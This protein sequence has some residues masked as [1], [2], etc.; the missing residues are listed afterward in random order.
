[1]WNQAIK[2]LSAHKLRLALT[3][4]AVILGVAFMAGTLVLTGTIKHTIDGL[5]RQTTSGYSVVVRATTSYTASGAF[6]GGGGGA[7]GAANSRPLTPESLIP[8][9]R[10]TPGVSDAVGSLQGQVALVSSEGKA[11]KGHASGAPTVALAWIPNPQ[12]SALKLRSGRGPTAPGELAIDADTASRDHVT[13]G[14]HVSVIGNGAPEPFTV[15]GIFGFG[16]SG[17]IA[18]AT[19]VAFDA[20]V[21]Q[22]LFGSPGYFDQIDVAANPGT[23]TDTLITDVGNRIPKGFE[24]VNSSTVAQENASTVNGFIGTFND[25]L[26]AFAFIALFVGAFL[27]FNTFSILVGQ[28]TRELALLRALGA[29][30]RQVRTS[31]ILEAGF[32]GLAGAIAG[33]VVGIL[34]AAGLLRL[35]RSYLGL[36]STGLVISPGTIV[37]SLLVGTLITVVAALGPSMRASRVPPVAAMREDA[38]VVETSLRRRAIIGSSVTGVGLLALLG[39]LFA[40]SSIALV[41]LG[42][43]LTFIGV[44]ML[45]P[46]IAAPVARAFAAPIAAVTGITGRLSQENAARN[47]RRTGATAT[48]LMIGLALVAAIATLATSATT[49]FG[50]I[51]TSTLKSD[52]V[53]TSTNNT[54]SRSAADAVRKAPGVTAVSPFTEVQMHIGNASHAMSAIDPVTGPQLIKISMVTGSTDALSKGQILVNSNVA[55]SDHL[56]VGSPITMGF[57]ASGS[58]TYTVGGT[59]KT[60]QLLDNYISSIPVVEAATNQLQYEA[61]LVKVANPSS[62]AQDAVSQAI[63]GYP[64]LTVKTTAQFVDQQK[65]QIQGVLRFVYV[66][67]AL[68]IIIGLIGVINTLLLSVLERT[69]EIG[70]LRAVG[71]LRRQVRSMIRGEAVVVSVLGAVLG[72]VLGVLFGAAIVESLSSSGITEIAIPWSTIIVVVIL[73]LLF[74][75]FAAIFPARRAARLDVLQAITTT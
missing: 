29:S 59:F 68:S 61:V 26:L 1:M 16:S 10:S 32:T 24:A 63:T 18:G 45:V 71:M 75:L 4:I 22:Q 36:S 52:Y 30:R 13:I 38:A 23:N 17:T 5:F 33:V 37:A 51:F 14:A 58:H 49:S 48:T 56:A 43:G 72:V 21:A 62:S 44:A 50:H 8:V 74:G 9:I 3:A 11:I 7:G 64:Q 55:K 73:A 27:I 60:N 12:M 46:F 6:S 19:I 35:L 34:L 2:N 42:A 69:H 54:F 15:V 40:G 41:G 53:V 67:L 65:Q 66:L 28:R 25:I 57:A 47:P 20:P 70:L 31:V 39:G